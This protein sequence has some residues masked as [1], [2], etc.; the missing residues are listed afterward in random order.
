[1]YLLYPFSLAIY[2]MIKKKY[3]F[4]LYLFVFKLGNELMRHNNVKNLEPILRTT[5]FIDTYVMVL[6]TQYYA[7]YFVCCP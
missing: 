1:M 6:I 4:F 3:I 5:H 2:V 7:I